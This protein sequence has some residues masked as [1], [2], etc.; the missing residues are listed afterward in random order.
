[1]KNLLLAL[2][3]GMLAFTATSRA[4]DETKPYALDKCVYSGEKLG[5]MG[6]PI[7]EVYEGQEMKFCCKDCKKEFD[8]D[9]AAGVKKYNAAV[10]ASKSSGGAR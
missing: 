5:E 4:A 8:K 3:I 6:K 7:S 9:P 10:T 1:M 2:T